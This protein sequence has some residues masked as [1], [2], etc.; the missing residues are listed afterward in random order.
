MS[1]HNH[2]PW[3]IILNGTP[4]DQQLLAQ[5]QQSHTLCVCDGAIEHLPI[6][7]LAIHTLIGDFD[8]VSDTTLS[9]L[10]QHNLCLI[11]HQPCQQST[12]CEKALHYCLALGATQITLLGAT[13][14]RMDHSVHHLHLLK[15]FT[16]H[17]NCHISIREQNESIQYLGNGQYT[18]TSQYPHTVSIL[19]FPSAVI[20]SSGLR[21]DMDALK[22]GE[23]TDSISNQLKAPQAELSIEG[24]A[25]LITH[26][27]IHVQ[28]LTS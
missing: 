15:R 1:T 5:Y 17:N 11:K 10:K 23:H 6:D 20:R 24:D 9:K 12:D 8:S 16:R 21:Y 14:G 26:P 28:R 13:G 18:L 25:L 27:H 19:G 4:C 2:Q 22:I 7:T 3:C